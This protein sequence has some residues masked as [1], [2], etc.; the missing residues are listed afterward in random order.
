MHNKIGDQTAQTQNNPDA[1]YTCPVCQR[2]F[3]NEISLQRHASYHKK[4]GEIPEGKN[5]SN[6]STCPPCDRGFENNWSYERHLMQHPDPATPLNPSG[7]VCTECGLV[8]TTSMSLRRHKKLKHYEMYLQEESL[9]SELNLR[10][11]YK[12][13]VCEKPIASYSSLQRHHKLVHTNGGIKTEELISSPDISNIDA[14]TYSAINSNSNE[15]NVNN[16]LTSL[17][18]C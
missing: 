16:N 3:M 10:K 5:L 11:K 1:Q 13:D 15:T 9:K 2:Q 12:C 18:S 17:V 14:I 7:K 6:Y 8:V 4:T